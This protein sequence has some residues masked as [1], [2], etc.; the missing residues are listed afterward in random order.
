VRVNIRVT[1]SE[2]GQPMRYN[3]DCSI[4]RFPDSLRG[5]LVRRRQHMLFF[6]ALPITSTLRKWLGLSWSLIHK[7]ESMIESR[8]F[9][10]R[11]AA[12]GRGRAD[13]LVQVPGVS[14]VCDMPCHSA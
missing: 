3:C 13:A 14:S 8:S 9:E 6:E 4:A 11:L 10:T 7:T 1:E 5:G 12:A 2:N